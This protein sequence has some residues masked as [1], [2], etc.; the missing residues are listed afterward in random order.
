M[1]KKIFF[2]FDISKVSIINTINP[3]FDFPKTST[4]YW[5]LKFQVSSMYSSNV[6]FRYG[7]ASLSST[8]TLTSSLMDQYVYKSHRRNFQKKKNLKNSLQPTLVI[9]EADFSKLLS[10]LLG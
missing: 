7:A 9:Y 6:K 1:T 10:S 3:K 2:L 8:S 5:H 4:S